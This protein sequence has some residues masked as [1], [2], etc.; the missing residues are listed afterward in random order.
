MTRHRATLSTIFIALALIFCAYMGYAQFQMSTVPPQSVAPGF[1][2]VTKVSDG[3]T[4]TVD[5]NGTA[6]TVRFIGV[7]TPETHKPNTPVQCFG[8][9]A[10]DFTTKTLTG[11]SVRL[12][13]DP[14]NDNRDR[15]DRLLRYVYTQDGTLLN[16]TL[17]EQG[18]GFAYLSFP[19]QKKQEFAAAQSRAQNAKSGLWAACP[20]TE[21]SGG[22]WQT[23]TQP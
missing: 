3:D 19:F 20:T 16:K 10:S 8:P 21:L 17:V 6:E 2:R 13:A 12:E 7:D 4:I 23:A 15:Y 11:A 1:Y 5:M 14:T 22:R 9:Q 18:Y